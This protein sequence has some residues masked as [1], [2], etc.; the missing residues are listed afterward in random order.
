MRSF[1]VLRKEAGLF[2]GSLLRKGEVFAYVGRNQNLM[3]LK[4]QF[5]YMPRAAQVHRYD[6]R[7]TLRRLHRLRSIATRDRV[8]PTPTLHPPAT[9][10]R[11][12]VPRVPVL[13]RE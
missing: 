8:T 6:K 10:R 11:S 7:R 1:A 3:D 2:C 13:F 9:T 4:F 12:S 5:Q